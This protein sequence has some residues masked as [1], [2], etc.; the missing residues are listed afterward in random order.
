[1]KNNSSSSFS[2]NRLTSFVIIISSLLLTLE[3]IYHNSSQ[4]LNVFKVIDYFILTF[5]TIEII[6]RFIK[7]NFSLKEIILSFKALSFSIFKGK[8]I[9]EKRREC[10]NELFWFTFDLSIL[11]L[12]IISLFFISIFKHP[13]ILSMFRVIRIFRIVRIFEINKTLRDIE[14]IIIS[15]IPTVF[16]FGTILFLIIFMYALIGSNIYNF[17]KF[18]TINFST[19]YDAIITLFTCLTNGWGEVHL[20]LR[21]TKVNYFITDFYIISFFV[22]CSMITLNLFLS[23]MI[24]QIQDKLIKKV[25]KKSFND[26]QKI[27]KLNDS[28]EILVEKISLLENRLNK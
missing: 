10:L 13:E 9:S 18:E 19:I 2:V 27:E 15:V 21:Q 1:M 11:I 22:S 24:S 3:T 25:D 6:F 20:E 16:I 26:S 4:L 7:F 8:N 28:I 14:K 17:K 23:V 12:S 5:F